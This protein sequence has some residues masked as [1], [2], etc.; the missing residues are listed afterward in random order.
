M[1]DTVIV[2]DLERVT[3]VEPDSWANESG[4]LDDAGG[5]EWFEAVDSIPADP[6]FAAIA[7]MLDVYR[8]DGHDHI[9]LIKAQQALV[10]F[11][12]AQLYRSMA[13]LVEIIASEDD[14]DADAPEEAAAAEIGAALNL[15]RRT[16]EY[17]LLTA[18]DLHRR[19]PSVLNALTDG[20]I[21]VRRAR[22]MVRGTEHLSIARARAV[23]DEVLPHASGLTSGQLRVELRRRCGYERRL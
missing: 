23:V 15:T 12:T 6:A 3:D 5:A 19:L 7:T 10:S 8:M 11:A 2:N 4:H 14:L 16:A 13:E 9:R 1:D 18:L 17:E 21:D 22:T 20:R